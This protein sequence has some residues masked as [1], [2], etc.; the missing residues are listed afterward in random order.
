VTAAPPRS[1]LALLGGSFDPPHRTHQRIAAAA[2]QQ[3][4]V[5]ELLVLP[6]GDHPHK[7]QRRQ[8]A[9][10]HRLQMCRIAFAGQD[11]VA[12]DDR[13]LRRP[14][15]SFTVDT[16]AELRA[17][18][19]QR[20]LWLLIGADNLRLLPTWRDHH[21]LLRLCRVATFPRHGSE[22][23][24]AALAG[25]DLTDAERAQLLAHALAFPADAVSSSDLR[26]RLASGERGLPE[27]P[28]GVEDYVRAHRLYGT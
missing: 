18:A 3:L 5:T 10:E 11:G 22:P 8:A 6:A 2:L 13:E 14:G 20:E 23:T 19:P 1:G 25:L 27:L 4:P 24:A 26:R 16:L 17:E 7:R 21:R 9:P 12:V 28:A 15:P